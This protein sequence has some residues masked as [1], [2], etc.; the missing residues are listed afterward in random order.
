MTSRMLLMNGITIQWEIYNL[1]T[2]RKN[3][4]ADYKM[5]VSFLLIGF[6]FDFL[7]DYNI[8]KQIR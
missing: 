8:L 5:A 2:W 4:K 7:P 1:F 3:I 6:L